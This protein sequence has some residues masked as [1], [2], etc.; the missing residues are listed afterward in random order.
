MNLAN[1]KDKESVSGLIQ[2]RQVGEVTGNMLIHGDNLSVLT[3]LKHRYTEKIKCIYIDPPYNTCNEFEHFNDTMSHTEWINT[4][5]PRL[6]LLWDFLREDG[7]IWISI[8]DTECHY[9]KILCDELWGRQNFLTMIV[10]QKNDYPYN[11]KR[12]KIVHMHDYVLVYSKNI[13]NCC[14]NEIPLYYLDEYFVNE[15]NREWIPD[16]ILEKYNSLDGNK[17][18]YSIT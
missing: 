15:E 16:S 2:K 10:R 9:L 13:E 5:K 3:K 8:D 18:V 12:R 4:L 17:Y 1:L 6:E 7:T 11:F 14:V